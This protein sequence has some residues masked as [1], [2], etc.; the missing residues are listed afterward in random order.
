MS[1]R[2]TRRKAS[3]EIRGRSLRSSDFPAP[4]TRNSTLKPTAQPA[5]EPILEPA[6]EVPQHAAAEEPILV[7]AEGPL[8]V[9]KSSRRCSNCRQQ[10]HYKQ[11]CPSTTSS[12][13]T[14]T[15]IFAAP[16]SSVSNALRRSKTG[17]LQMAISIARTE[18]FRPEAER[19]AFSCL[20]ACN[21]I[22]GSNKHKKTVK[23]EGHLS[24]HLSK[25]HEL[26]F[27]ALVRE[28]TVTNAQLLLSRH[29]KSADPMT[30]FCTRAVPPKQHEFFRE[31]KL[32]LWMG[33]VLA[34]PSILNDAFQDF[35]MCSGA[36][37]VVGPATFRTRIVP[38]VANAIRYKNAELLRAASIVA[39]TSDSVSKGGFRFINMT[40]HWIQ[41]PSFQLIALTGDNFAAAERHLI[42]NVIDLVDVEWGKNIPDCR[43]FAATTDSGS[44]MKA[45]FTTLLER[46]VPCTCHLLNCAIKAA[47]SKLPA[48]FLKD[49]DEI[50]S[51]SVKSR[52]PNFR[53]QLESLQFRSN[54]PKLV[55]KTKTTI[56]WNQETIQIERFLQILP[57]LQNLREENPA[58]F[59]AENHDF[60]LRVNPLIF[61]A[62]LRVFS[63]T[64]RL[65]ELCGG[66]TYPTLS[67]V[68][69]A[70][71]FIMSSFEN[72]LA[73]AETMIPLERSLVEALLGEIQ[74]R[75]AFIFDKHHVSLHL[76]A[77]ALDPKHGRLH[78]VSADHRDAI[79]EAIHNSILD[80]C[81][82][83]NSSVSSDDEF[84][85][86]PSSSA[87]DTL[88]SLRRKF[89][90]PDFQVTDSLL[91]W[92]KVSS[93]IQP[94]FLRFV[95]GILAT[96][97]SSVPSERN[98]SVVGRVLDAK[99]R[100]M[101]HS[102][103]SDWVTIY[104]FMHRQH[105]TPEALCEYLWAC[106]LKAV[107]ER[108]EQV[109]QLE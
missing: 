93:K 31:I 40:Y 99:R 75:F 36:A 20:L 11:K 42:E 65:S 82:K 14:M 39:V 1:S 38:L 101:K 107:K 80:F 28:P 57:D 51:L 71:H 104:D 33:S 98:N 95:L 10:G 54:R 78:F 91:F 66:E 26:P 45:A 16:S 74:N 102:T 64:S 47:I 6:S 85:Q 23:G 96:P 30:R 43:P 5:E 97:A 100:K 19:E 103:C 7:A 41:Q 56:R 8:E 92:K 3:R 25:W 21:Q 67:S 73:S 105:F 37:A 24:A 29:S 2:S 4:P 86:P 12:S 13:S 70:V 94:E 9:N 87:A 49:F 35:L 48:D 69:P 109:I 62:F 46:H 106:E 58:L 90:K 79:W 34:S 108:A 81:G 77:S 17:S 52:L 59:S 72:M 15:E 88:K 44:D 50:N 18:W 68:A 55:G 63:S 32:V 27:A 89:E 76:I 60:L 61:Q 84:W 22:H 83:E 53:F